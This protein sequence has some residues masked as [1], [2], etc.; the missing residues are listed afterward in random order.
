MD[1]PPAPERSSYGYPA[2]DDRTQIQRILHENLKK[3]P[4]VEAVRFEESG[5]E[6]EHQVVGDID[7]AVYADGIVD[8]EEAFVQVNWWPLSDEDQYWHQFHYVE[9]GGFDCGW[10]R[11][12]NDHVEG[13]GHYQER[14]SADGDYEYYPT[15]L[16]HENPVG[17]LWEIMRH[18]L[19]ERLKLRYD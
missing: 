9:S 15:N 4:G 8:A 5:T 7:T 14:E 1:P 16:H 17:I 19:V 2:G 18:R 10:H 6:V 11:Q 12:E 3:V 13:L